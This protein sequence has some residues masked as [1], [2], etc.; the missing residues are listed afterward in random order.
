[1][2]TDELLLVRLEADV[3]QA[4]GLVRPPLGSQIVARM[5]SENWRYSDCQFSSI[6]TP[7]LDETMNRPKEIGSPS[8]ATRTSLYSW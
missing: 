4:L 2:T 6:A 1:M 5:N 3:F 7:K 8:C